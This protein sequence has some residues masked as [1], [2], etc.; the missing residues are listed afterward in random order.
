MNEPENENMGS[1]SDE[2]F[3]K[4][5]KTTIIVFFFNYYCF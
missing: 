5:Q 1:F 2:T 3:K 4:K